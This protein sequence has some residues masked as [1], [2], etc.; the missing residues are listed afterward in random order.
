MGLQAILTTMASRWSVAARDWDAAALAALYTDD[1][2]LFG[3]RPEHSTGGAGIRAYFASYEG[4]ILSASLTLEEQHIQPIDARA[5][6]ARGYGEFTFTLA[7]NRQTISRM[8]TTWLLVDDGG[9]RIRTHH[10][11]PLPAAPPLGD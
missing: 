7:G 4:V 10:F 5:F 8:R 6:L 9:W 2:L 11:S 3:G 1:A